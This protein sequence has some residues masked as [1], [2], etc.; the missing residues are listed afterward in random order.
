MEALP[1]RPFPYAL[2]FRRTSSNHTGS[3]G[4]SATN[5]GASVAVSVAAGR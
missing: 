5:E 1:R 3:G 4:T 2:V